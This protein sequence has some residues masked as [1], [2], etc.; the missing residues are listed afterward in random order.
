MKKIAIV[1]RRMVAGGIESALIS[2]LEKINKNKYEVTLFV[3]AEGGEFI[4]YIPDWVKIVPIYGVEKSLA[5]KVFN[6]VKRG[7]FL[8]A[9]KVGF[10]SIKSMKVNQG[11]ESE[12]YLAKTLQKVDDEFDIAIAYH[13]PASF[14]VIYTSDFINAK[15]KFAWVHSDVEVYKKELERY[16]EYYDKFDKI[17]CVSKYAMNK[18][19]NQYPHLK[20]KTRVFYN[21]INTKKIYNLANEFKAFEDNFTGI[22]ILTVGRL[23]EQ[24]G[25]DIIPNIIK[26]LKKDNLSFKWYLVGD[27]ELGSNLKELIKKEDIEEELILLGTK[28]NPYP[29]FSKCDIY[30]QPSRH[31]GYCITLAEAKLFNKPIIATDFVGAREQIVNEKNGL[32]VEFDRNCIK[33]SI[34]RLINDEKL[35]AKF[36]KNLSNSNINV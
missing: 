36:S 1:T 21:I 22:R 6:N 8:N 2:M 7:R 5:R 30:V 32:I 23:T 35:R 24:K 26:Q 28:T 33:N 34:K 13:V 20:N 14:P 31:E 17:Y 29:Y 15:Q 11:Y 16:I 3:M 10:Y 25:Q 12:K 19:N 18:F 4:E 27:G 9:F